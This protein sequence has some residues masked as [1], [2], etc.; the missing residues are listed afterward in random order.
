MQPTVVSTIE[1][2]PVAKLIPYARNART[3]S[4]AQVDQIAASIVEFGFVNPILVGENNVI[5]AGHCRL[6]AAQK[7]GMDVVPVIVLSHLS[8]TQRR[9]LII[10]DNQLALG[11]GW[12]EEMLHLELAELSE[13]DFD[14]DLL[15]FSDA[16]LDKYL[17]L[18]TD[19]SKEAEESVPEPEENPIARLGDIWILGEHRLM[20]GDSTN[21]DDVNRLM[22][23]GLADMVVQDPPYNVDYGNAAKDKMRHN[24]RTIL[25]DN[26]GNQ[27]YDFLVAVLK[28]SLAVCKGAVYVSMS[29]SELDTLQR[30]FIEAGG[31]WSTFI[32]WAKNHFTMGRSDY[33]RQYEPILYGWKEGEERFWCGVRNESDL[34]FVDK[35]VKNDI[36]PTMKPVVLFERAIKN[37]SKRRDI[38]LDLFGGS[39]TTLIACE[40]NER[41]ARLME[42]DPKYVDVI[43]KRWQE[44]CGGVAVHAETGEVFGSIPNAPER[45]EETVTGKTA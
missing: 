8:D 31:K 23:G 32:I 1:Q 30:A 11:A 27:F 26:L 24:K 29:S 39:G 37:S 36:H 16:D 21:M 6:L 45:N 12:S 34:W 22:D 20:C 40:K 44:F 18:D 3:H 15:G 28:N 13:L 25:N 42:L 9:A 5:V 41:K 43:I 10:A 35:P 17:S 4:D 19:E 38:V 2:W 33:Q 7:L 14:L